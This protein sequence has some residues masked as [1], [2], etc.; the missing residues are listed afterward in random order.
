MTIQERWSIFLSAPKGLHSQCS[1]NPEVLDLSGNK[2]Q[3]LTNSMYRSNGFR[4]VYAG[5]QCLKS[6]HTTGHRSCL[7]SNYHEFVQRKNWT[8][9]LTYLIKVTHCIIS[10]VWHCSRWRGHHISPGDPG[11]AEVIILTGNLLSD[12]ATVQ[13]ALWHVRPHHWRRG[14]VS[15][16]C[17]RHGNSWRGWWW[18]YHQGGIHKTRS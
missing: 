14:V 10:L 16:Q 15:C 13:G 1:R 7:I 3:I 4:R 6:Q 17:G 5:H 11:L 18:K 12:R 9:C 8:G 2:L